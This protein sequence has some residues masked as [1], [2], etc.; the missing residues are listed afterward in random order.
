MFA[1]RGLVVLAV[2]ALALAG[3]SG[4]K[5]TTNSTTPTT[6]PPQPVVVGLKSATPTT[7]DQPI[8]D[9]ITA[10]QT[11]A[12]LWQDDAVLS[13][14]SVELPADLGVNNA[15]NTY[16]YG[17]Q[18]DSADWW[19]YSL[20]EKASKSVRAII[21]KEDYLGSA[22]VPINTQYWKMN[23]VEAFQLA[24]AN[25]GSD[26]RTQHTDARVTL[27]LS[28]RDPNQWLWWTI[29]YKTPAGG[30]LTLLVNPNRGEVLDSTG[31]Q[32]AAPPTTSGTPTTSTGTSSSTATTPSSGTSG[33]TTTGTSTTTSSSSSSYTAPTTTTP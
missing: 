21:P 1:R 28:H 22:I 32:V 15:T 16:V 29:Q 8:A 2:S 17:S 11:K 18:K 7:F 20:A 25:G 6:T 27:Y 5:T 3:C 19:T 30:L 4:K 13:Y 33:T 26:F 23:Y 24:D 31:K 12:K 9:Q 10:A 14:V